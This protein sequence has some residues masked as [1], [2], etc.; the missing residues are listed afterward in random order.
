MPIHR[1]LPPK[2]LQAREP[3]HP[4]LARSL[5]FQIPLRRTAL[6]RPAFAS[7]KPSSGLTHLITPANAPL[8]SSFRAEFPSS[9]VVEP[10]PTGSAAATEPQL[11]SKLSTSILPDRKT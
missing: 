8:L 3:L 9:A 4:R 1:A 6:H 11:P 7:S 2:T 5:G 10:S